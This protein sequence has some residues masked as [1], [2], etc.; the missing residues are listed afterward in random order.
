LV[1]IWR[2]DEQIP[3]TSAPCPG[4]AGRAVHWRRVLRLRRRLPGATTSLGCAIGRGHF[5]VR[6]RAGA[7]A[8]RVRCAMGAQARPPSHASSAL[9]SGLRRRLAS[10]DFATRCRS[11]QEGL[12][13][14][15]S[16]AHLSKARRRRCTSHDVRLLETAR[17]MPS[18]LG[19]RRPCSPHG[20]SLSPQSRCSTRLRQGGGVL[21]C[22]T[23]TSPR[24]PGGPATSDAQ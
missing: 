11:H 8:S 18:P 4:A 6:P 22:G 24:W 19:R 9:L 3:A 17:S 7:R 20:S 10:P 2:K 14:D 13:F 15:A 1:P 5:A 16:G 12:A 21:W 23:L